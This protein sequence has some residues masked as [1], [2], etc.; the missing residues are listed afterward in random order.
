MQ[1]FRR[2]RGK[3]AGGIYG[4]PP[5]VPA[6]MRPMETVNQAFQSRNRTSLHVPNMLATGQDLIKLTHLSVH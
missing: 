2:F 1:G 3:I 4:R 6:P 5:S